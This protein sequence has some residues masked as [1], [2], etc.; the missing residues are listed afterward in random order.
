M[1]I[2]SQLKLALSPRKVMVECSVKPATTD[3]VPK[4]DTYRIIM[5]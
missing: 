1:H 3:N 2:L 4:E 5:V